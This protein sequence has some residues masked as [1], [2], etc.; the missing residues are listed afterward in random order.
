[1]TAAAKFTSGGEMKRL[2]R[3]AEPDVSI[4]E[5]DVKDPSKLARLVFGLAKDLAQLRRRFAPRRIDFEDI[6]VDDTGT[7]K[8]RF[9]HGFNGQVRW[10]VVDA[11][12]TGSGGPILTR[13][14]DTSAN[15]LVLVSLAACLVTVRVEEAG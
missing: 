10:W 14:E 13:H 1:M 4:T 7:K 15:V 11:V 6:G 8:F 3:P 5:D 12:D 9:E 2:D